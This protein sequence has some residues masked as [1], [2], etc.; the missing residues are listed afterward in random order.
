MFH[1]GKVIEVFSPKH[2]KVQASDSTVQAMLDMWDENTLTVMVDKKLE[3]GIRKDD[4]VLVD[5]TTPKL[6]VTKI[7]RDEV[8]KSTWK[9]YKDHHQ[10]RKQATAMQRQ[11][12]LVMQQESYV[13]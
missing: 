3:T 1:P 4:I 12:P 9:Q 7:L 6:R 2:K 5:Y 11:P 8:A 13:G 10:K